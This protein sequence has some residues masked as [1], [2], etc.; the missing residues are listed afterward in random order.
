MNL[1]IAAG[2]DEHKHDRRQDIFNLPH[3]NLLSTV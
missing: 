2:R 1:A 3:R